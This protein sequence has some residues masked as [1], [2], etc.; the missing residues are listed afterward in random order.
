MGDPVTISLLVASIG[1]AVG[2]A[3]VKGRAAKAQAEAI[4]DAAEFNALRAEQAGAAEE[5]R[6]RRLNRRT[7][8][9]QRVQFAKAGVRLEG[10]PLEFLAQNAAELELNALQARIAGANTA[11]LERERAEVALDAGRVSAGAA[12]LEGISGATGAALSTQGF[13]GAAP[14]PSTSLPKGS[15]I[16]SPFL[17]R[18]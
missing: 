13:G 3:V 2:G 4:A 17:D 6:V 18:A 1:T 10:T 5:S 8:S 16:A 9:S 11:R 7:L 12:L 15:R 14:A